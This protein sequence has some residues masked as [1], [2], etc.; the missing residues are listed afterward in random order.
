MKF[1]YIFIFSIVFLI[2]CKSNNLDRNASKVPRVRTEMPY[3]PEAEENRIEGWIRLS[4]DIGPNGK[5]ININ[6]I[7]SFPQGVFDNSAKEAFS[8]WYWIPK[9]VNNKAVISTGHTIKF[10]YTLKK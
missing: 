6:V 10:S 4:Y 7:E 9:V 3:P 8:N 5:T 2:G 1:A